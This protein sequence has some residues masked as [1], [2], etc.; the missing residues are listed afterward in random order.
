MYTYNVNHELEKLDENC[1]I[2]PRW[3]FNKIVKYE[4]MKKND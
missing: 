2:K 1:D 4:L 3:G